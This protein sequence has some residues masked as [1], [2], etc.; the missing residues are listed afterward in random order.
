MYVCNWCGWRGEDPDIEYYEED[1]GYYGSER[2]FQRM[3][4][5]VCPHCGGRA[6]ED[7]YADWDDE[8]EE[9]ECA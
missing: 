6:H 7:I 4:E 3:G 2:V 5:A 1:R 8:E 9:E